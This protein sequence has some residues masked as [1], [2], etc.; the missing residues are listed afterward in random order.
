MHDRCNVKFSPRQIK[1]HIH[2]MN[3]IQILG[4]CKSPL[5][6]MVLSVLHAPHV[7]LTFTTNNQNFKTSSR[8]FKLSVLKISYSTLHVYILLLQAPS[9]W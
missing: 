5:L 8:L 4:W 2:Y 9:K 1:K 7:V 6:I 3:A